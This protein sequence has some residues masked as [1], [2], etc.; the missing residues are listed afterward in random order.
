MHHLRGI[1]SVNSLIILRIY[2]RR[3]DQEQ[4]KQE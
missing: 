1:I 3:R 2:G 4:E